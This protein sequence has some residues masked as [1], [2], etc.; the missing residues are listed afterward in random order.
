M[1][2]HR[3]KSNRKVTFISPHVYSEWRQRMAA[4][5]VLRDEVGLPPERL[6][7]AVWYHQ[8]LRR[9]QLQTLDGQSLRVL[10]PGFWN[11]EA[12]P[13]FQGAV[14]QLGDQA[15]RSG[16]VEIDLVPGG[17]HGHAH[18]GNPAYQKVLLH[19]VWEWPR[20]PASALPT[21][22]LK[23]YLDAPLAELGLWLGS[24]PAKQMPGAVRGQCGAPLKNLPAAKVA[25]LLQ[26]AAQTRLQAKA[27][28][29][30]A[31]ARQT[32]WEQ[33][34]WEGLFGALGYKQN[35]WPMRCLA[36][37]LPLLREPGV[38]A[39]LTVPSVQ[40]W[41][42]GVGGLL[43]A[44]LMRHQ[45][46]GAGY[47]RQTWDLWWRERDRYTDVILPRSL[48][49]F[50]G[51]RPANHPQR[52][53][54][55]AAHWLAAGDIPAR[56]EQWLATPRTGTAVMA[57]LLEILAVERDEYWS[58]Q[59]TFRSARLA[60]P[61]PLLGAARLTDLVMNVILPWFWARATSGKNE[62]LR[63]VAENRY[64]AWPGAEDNTVLRLARQRLLGG[65]SARS[66]KTAAAQQGLL[67]IVRDF[68]NQS[69]AVCTDCQFPE[70]LRT[71][72]S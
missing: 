56:L 31:R 40:A 25:E 60:K 54:A 71:I 37:L 34:L 53:L 28:Q 18:A 58:W 16:D 55:L 13:D 26:Q 64:L 20:K 72:Q 11:H 29:F 8:R 9:D 51:Q 36:E 63:Q 23:P 39:P 35:V 50:H 48:W 17:W 1:Q 46:D 62:A 3:L 70:L 41:L 32:G 61:Q 67:Q 5:P 57:S 33:A 15:P 42:L 66:F 68:C 10:H 47:L 52:R 21:L 22:S 12:G 14:V 4:L 65:T 44:D 49:R 6:L 24:D 45:P 69:N 2:E 43:P 38:S 30:A 27:A 7:Q 19:V 59:W